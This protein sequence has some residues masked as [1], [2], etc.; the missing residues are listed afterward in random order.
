MKISYRWLKDY[1]DINISPEQLAERLAEIGFDIETLENQADKYKNFVIGKVVEVRKHPNA[2]KLSLCKVDVGKETLGVVCGA[3]NVAA[4]QFVCFAKVGAVIPASGIELKKAKIRGE[5]SE[6]MICSAKEMELGDDHTGIMDLEHFS[7]L[8]HLVKDLEIGKPFAEYLG[9]DDIVFDIGITPNR[10]DLLSH[11]GVA[12]ECTFLLSEKLNLPKIE[13][14]PSPDSI[15]NYIDVEIL[16][17]KLC[18]RYCGCFVKN[19]Q[20][21]DSPKWMQDYLTAA[22]LRP[23]NN[24]VDVTNFVMLETGQPLHAFDY[25]VI[26]NKKIRVKTASGLKSFKTLDGKERTLKDDVLLI[27]DAEKPLGIAG[28]MGGENSEIKPE[29]KDV[30]IESAFFDPVNIRKS[31]K[32]LGLQTDSSYRFERGVD[33]NMVEFACK[34]AASLIAQ[35]SGAEWVGGFIDNYPT[36]IVKRNIELQLSYAEKIIGV[37]IDSETAKNLLHAIGVEAI[38]SSSGSIKFVIP[39]HRHFDI[40]EDIDLIEEIARLYGYSRIPEAESDSIFYETRK[41]SDDFVGFVNNLRSYLVGRGFKEIITNTLV[42]EEHARLFDSE[43][44]RLVNPSSE[45]MNVLR[46]NLLVG[47]LQAMKTNFNFKAN[48]LKLFEFG[49]TVIYDKEIAAPVKGIREQQSALLTMAGEY[50]H[51]TLTQEVR[52]FD[53]FDLKGEVQVLLEKLNIDNYELNDYNYGEKFEHSLEFCVNEREI[54]RVHEISRNLLAGFNIN[55]RVLCCELNLNALYLISAKRRKYR[56]ISKYPPVL[57]DLSIMLDPAIKASQ[58][59]KEIRKSSDGL[60]KRVRLYDVYRVESEGMKKKSYTFALEFSS[61]EKTLTD[62]EINLVQN[63]LI[64]SLQK[65][66]KAELRK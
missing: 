36:P 45:D 3:P 62:E 30:F 60:L 58:V 43:Y 17:P 35:L 51:E 12:R 56:E 23:I 33:I 19:V 47:A 13:P 24:I 16:D 8:A 41:Y 31:S 66:L 34:R 49:D 42:D 38:E 18:Y 44:V 20:L 64:K 53:I 10:G 2:D 63:K 28:I 15:K 29:T 21:K 39:Y 40:E 48:S 26:S 1:V 14:T 7:P 9:R 22:G 46:T 65:H 11:I 57:R 25:A 59:E 4:R 50:D 37:K 32:F 27:C 55:K 52:S 5:S 54:A 6:G 61:D